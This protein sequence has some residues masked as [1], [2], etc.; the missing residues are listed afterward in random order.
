MEKH[1]PERRGRI[2]DDL[3]P[4]AHGEY[5]VN[6]SDVSRQFYL[7]D[8]GKHFASQPYRYQSRHGLSNDAL[9]R[10]AGIDTHP[11]GH[12]VLL[13]RHYLDAVIGDGAHGTFTADQITLARFTALFHEVGE[14][15]HASLLEA[16]FSP[17]GD[18]P[19]GEKTPE[20]KVEESIIR[21]HIF[22][23]D[24]AFA[25]IDPT[26]IERAEA[27]IAH[28]PT[29]GDE[30][31]HELIET[32]HT[33]QGFDAAMTMRYS[34]DHPQEL[35]DDSTGEMIT[36]LGVMA[37]SIGSDTLRDLKGK[38]SPTLYGKLQ[39]TFRLPSHFID[40]TNERFHKLCIPTVAVT[41][42]LGHLARLS[43]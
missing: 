31:I 38:L 22:T 8:I 27:I 2:F 3:L 36:T 11:I 14:S 20:Q 16:G 37:K 13:A 33:L 18:I 17:I 26:F 28:H 29:E 12:Q 21:H 40:T 42:H 7:G 34:H 6:L 39:D 35:T 23:T 9:R 1:T 25:S 41:Q 19:H 15:T 30:R 5:T 32:A 10:N 4:D 43:A 24:E